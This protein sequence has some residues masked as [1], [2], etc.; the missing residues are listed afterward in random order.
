MVH[1]TTCANGCANKQVAVKVNLLENLT[2]LG[3]F[4]GRINS[5]KAMNAKTR[6]QDRDPPS[7]VY[8]G[9]TGVH[10]RIEILFRLPPQP[11][12][13]RALYP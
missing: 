9:N 6:R 11:S 2:T 10:H 5:L 3:D 8:F 1:Y 12:A 4:L 7:L 13:F